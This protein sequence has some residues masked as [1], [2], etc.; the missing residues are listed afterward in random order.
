MHQLWNGSTPHPAE[1][2]G[3]P[4][5]DVI[6][7][8]SRTDAEKRL[9]WLCDEWADAHAINMLDEWRDLRMAIHGAIQVLN[10]CRERHEDRIALMELGSLA[11]Q[12]SQDCIIA[13][14]YEGAK[15]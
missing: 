6:A 7:E 15:Q 9:E 10:Y 2:V 1:L 14:R 5:V 11:L 13:G 8:D 12:H 3:F 4:S